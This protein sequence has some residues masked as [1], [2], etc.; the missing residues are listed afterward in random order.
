MWK[1]IL[2]SVE[3]PSFP[4]DEMSLDIK[5]QDT[6]TGRELTKNYHLVASNFKDIQDVKDLALGELSKLNKFDGMK[7]KVATFIGKEIK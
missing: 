7:T 5:F 4:S 1:A 2:Q 3:T 6:D